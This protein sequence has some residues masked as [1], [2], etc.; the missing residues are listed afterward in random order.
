MESFMYVSSLSLWLSWGTPTPNPGPP[1]Q[2]RTHPPNSFRMNFGQAL[3]SVK[4]DEFLQS[5]FSGSF[6]KGG[7]AS[8]AVLVPVPLYIVVE[9]CCSIVVK[10][11]CVHFII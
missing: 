6:P 4:R 10:S 7:V 8:L 9:S 1:K 3:P 5:E 11:Q 2:A